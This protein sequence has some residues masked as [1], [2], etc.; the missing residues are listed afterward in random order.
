[1]RLTRRQFLRSV[2]SVTALS[3]LTGLY[4]WQVEPHWVQYVHRR[5]PIR[6]LPAHLEGKTLVQLSDLHIG[7]QVNA[8][9]LIQQ[10]Q[11]VAQLQPDFVVYTGDFVSYH[12]VE[13]FSQLYEVMQHTPHGRLGTAAVLG[14]HDY[15][16]GWQQG[17]GG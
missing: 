5:L 15:G 10:L 17:S 16:H 4:T 6:Y 2:A 7:N 8:N 1:M 14:N 11:K 13:Q 9:Y 3:A 12:S